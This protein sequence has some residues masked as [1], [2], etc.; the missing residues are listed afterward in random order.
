[1]MSDIDKELCYV[2]SK[3]HLGGFTGL[4]EAVNKA[5]EESRAAAKE[6]SYEAMHR[7]IGDY[8]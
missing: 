5:K 8:E 2:A 6:I 3:L 4:S 1:M 7:I